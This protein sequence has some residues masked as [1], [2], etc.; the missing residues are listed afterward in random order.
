MLF[1]FV[2]YNQYKYNYTFLE[3]PQNSLEEQFVFFFKLDEG[4]LVLLKNVKE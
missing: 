1:P 2:P 4:N 3:F